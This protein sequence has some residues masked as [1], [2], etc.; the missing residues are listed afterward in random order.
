MATPA[1]SIIRRATD[2]LQDKASIHWFANELVRYLND[3]QREVLIHRPDAL[4]TTS[5]ITLV[6]G[7][8]QDMSTMNLTPPPAKLIDITRNM[9]A[10]SVKGA[11]RQC[12][13]GIL[14]RQV[15]GWHAIVGTVD[16]KH[17]MFDPRDPRVFYV[18][19]PALG[20]AQLEVVYAG[21]PVDVV[22]PADGDTWNNVAGNIGLPDIY[23]NALL[24]YVLYRAYSQNTKNGGDPAR[25]S[26]HFSAFMN[27]LPSEVSVAP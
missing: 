18:Y 12:E 4:N 23:G 19:P 6:A 24:D 7:T 2:L 8:R 26:A 25:A 5:T 22:E 20:T 21:Y 11:V 1:K 10:T 14:D 9:A 17:F 15:P 13:R 27:A 16:I 3:G